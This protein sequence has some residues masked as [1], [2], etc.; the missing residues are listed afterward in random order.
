MAIN[1]QFCFLSLALIIQI[2]KSVSIG[3]PCNVTILPNRLITD[4]QYCGT[5]SQKEKLICDRKKGNVCLGTELFAGCVTGKCANGHFCSPTGVCMKCVDGCSSCT[6]TDSCLIC[7]TGYFLTPKTKLCAKL[8]VP[9]CIYT[10]NNDGSGC[11]A[12]APSYYYYKLNGTC[13]PCP[14]GCSSCLNKDTCNIGGCGIGKYWDGVAKACVEGVKNCMVENGPRDCAFCAYGYYRYEGQ[15]TVTCEEGPANCLFVYP[16]NT[17][18]GCLTGYFQDMNYT[19]KPIEVQNCLESSTGSDCTKCY[20]GYFL[21]YECSEIIEEENVVEKPPDYITQYIYDEYG[22]VIGE[23]EVY[24]GQEDDE[25]EEENEEEEGEEEVVD[26]EQNQDNQN[27]EEQQNYEEEQQNQ[28]GEEEQQNQEGEEEQQ[29]QEGEEE[30]Q[31]QEGE[32]E[33][34]NQEGEEE[35]EQQNQDEEEQNNNF[36]E[37]QENPEEEEMNQYYGTN[38][39]EEITC[40]PGYF[41]PDGYSACEAC[42]NTTECETC[43]GAK[44]A[45]CKTCA[46][47]FAFNK[48]SI[49]TKCHSSC[50]K[51]NDRNEY[52]CTECYEGYYLNEEEGTCTKCTDFCK[53]CDSDYTC[54]ECLEMYTLVYG[55]C[56]YCQGEYGGCI[57]CS[58]SGCTEA[59]PGFYIYWGI[60]MKC[61]TGCKTCIEDSYCDS[62][63]DGYYMY[64]YQCYPSG[65][66]CENY[67]ENDGCLSAKAGYFIYY[68]E[69][70]KCGEGDGETSCLDSNC[71]ESGCTTPETGSFLDYG[72]ARL[73]ERSDATG[74][75]TTCDPDYGCTEAA[76]GGYLYDKQ[77][78]KCKAPCAT[79]S[80][81]WTCTSCLDDGIHF[82]SDYSSDCVTCTE[83]GY[84][85]GCVAG[86]CTSTGCSEANEGYYLDENNPGVAFK[87]PTQCKTCW[88]GYE[89]Y[90]PTCEECADGYLWKEDYSDCYLPDNCLESVDAETCNK[91]IDGYFIAENNDGI[92]LNTPC[93]PC[94]VSHC[95]DCP[96]AVDLTCYLCERGF[97]LS[98]EQDSCGEPCSPHCDECADTTH[99]AVCEKGYFIF[100]GQCYQCYNTLTCKN[101]IGEK[102]DDCMECTE[103]Y[104]KFPGRGC[105]PCTQNVYNTVA[106]CEAPPLNITYGIIERATTKTLT[107]VKGSR[108]SVKCAGPV[109]YC[110]TA[111]SST[112][113][114]ICMEGY[115]LNLTEYI[116]EP[117][118]DS[119]CKICKTVGQCSECRTG[120]YLKYLNNV[121]SC[122]TC[123]QEKCTACSATTCTACQAG[124]KLSNEN[125]CVECTELSKYDECNC[126]SGTYWDATNKHC[127]SCSSNCIKCI[128]QDRCTKCS[129]G[130][131]LDVGTKSCKYN[132]VSGCGSVFE[133]GTCKIC[134]AGRYFNADSNTCD[135]CSIKWPGCLICDS[136]T[137]Y[138]CS[139]GFYF[140]A[141]KNSC[142]TCSSAIINCAT[143]SSGSICDQCANGYYW[144]SAAS[145]CQPCMK[146]CTL[147]ASGTTC[148]ACTDNYVYSTISACISCPEGCRKCE[149]EK[150]C[151]ICN[152]GYFLDKE[153]ELC[154]K[155]HG[156]CT[157]CVGQSLANCTECIETAEMVNNLCTCK[158]GLTYDRIDKACVSLLKSYG[159]NVKDYVIFGLII[160]GILIIF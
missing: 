76:D 151:S 106:S 96:N 67:V 29:N 27:Q 137:C 57:E 52:S 107:C 141:A 44:K 28:E 61:P 124:Y 87:C 43:D 113:C 159:L 138:T 45:D 73:C 8:A 56:Y 102:P 21:D 149:N 123:P 65:D 66:G 50:K 93:V 80:D 135:S 72:V 104:Y 64:N 152:K 20:P 85:N 3:T 117:C 145:A 58:D 90:Y 7:A 120:Y 47:G 39:Y 41:S 157:K 153:Y 127:D 158:N 11:L 92:V 12:C 108:I 51:C 25:E 46:A 110:E 105:L 99:C 160:I 144:D 35:E 17:C 68:G 59:E 9:N 1:L 78:Y 26:E 109:S 125:K 82:W 49:C 62:C 75:C 24:V 89:D 15:D 101:C 97:Y 10:S 18:K 156:L 33:Q 40:D 146:G 119:G 60:S 128:S 142:T 2:C 69:A 4:D 34:Q 147:C 38:G 36:E 23:Y 5:D 54:G 133:T 150:K 70:I 95:L 53:K 63:E 118:S 116:C 129:D 32:E 112:T 30:Q 84:T 154:G 148:E 86:A 134:K 136:V 98:E 81:Q 132:S 19:C 140:D 114:S 126:A 14:L 94:A 100:E 13:E 77:V 91:C 88:K 111:S 55:N 83:N 115:Y 22:N 16:M 79:C 74:L 37:Y 6:N 155:C 103:G 31:D 48:Y 130:N 143:C 131:Y 121:Y 139:S 122:M 42:Y 71:G